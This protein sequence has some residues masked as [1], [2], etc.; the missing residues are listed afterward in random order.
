M[1]LDVESL[2]LAEQ[3]YREADAR[4]D[5]LR[6]VRDELVACA[7]R[8]GWTHAQIA[9]ATGLSRGRIGQIAQSIKP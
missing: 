4:A 9:A 1:S 8:N 3:D 2:R 6:A 7:L 5:D